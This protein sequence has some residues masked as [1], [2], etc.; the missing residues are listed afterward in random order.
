M[1]MRTVINRKSILLHFLLG[2]CRQLS[3]IHNNVKTP[4]VWFPVILPQWVKILAG[5]CW[6]GETVEAQFLLEVATESSS[7]HRIHSKLTL[8]QDRHNRRTS[9]SFFL[10]LLKSGL[11]SEL[12]YLTLVSYGLAVEQTSQWLRQATVN[13]PSN[14]S[15]F[16]RLPQCHALWLRL[17]LNIPPAP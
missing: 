7:G 17:R 1:L 4:S 2:C 12:K 10:R 8:T 3:S 6:S 5:G 13:L 9:Q 16:S 14:V 15:V 11:K